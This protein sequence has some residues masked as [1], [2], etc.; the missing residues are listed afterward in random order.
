MAVKDIVTVG[1]GPSSVNM[2]PT[3]GFNSSA[4]TVDYGT[5]W[6]VVAQGSFTPLKSQGTFDPLKSQ[7][8]WNALQQL[9]VFTSGD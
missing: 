3:R 2:I 8:D 6:L 9:D 5:V 1:F 4:T 7:D